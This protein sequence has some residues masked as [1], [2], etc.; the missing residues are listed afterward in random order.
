VPEMFI[1][2]FENRAVLVQTGTARLAR[3]LLQNV[4]RRW[5]RREPKFTDAICRLRQ[6]SERMSRALL[7]GDIT[8]VCN[9][10]NEFWALKKLVAGAEQAEPKFVRELFDLTAQ[11][12][13]S[14]SVCGAG[15][16]GF[17]VLMLK[18]SATFDEFVHLVKSSFPD[19]IVSPVHVCPR[20]LCSWRDDDPKHYYNV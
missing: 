12:T 9:E 4:V 3:D 10:L 8:N 19:M 18:E 13:D 6:N 7:E 14:R 15:G 16:G 5:H 1:N 20:G 11:L 17:A 2:L